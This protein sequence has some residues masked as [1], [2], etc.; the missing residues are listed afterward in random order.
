MESSS[1]Q[2]DGLAMSFYDAIYVA[3]FQRIIISSSNHISSHRLTLVIKMMIFA[4]LARFFAID[5]D[6]ALFLW[7]DYSL[8]FE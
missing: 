3:F 6:L 5:G 2:R 7:H 4:I 8:F 1:A